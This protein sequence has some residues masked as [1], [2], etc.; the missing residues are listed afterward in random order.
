MVPSRGSEKASGR[1]RERESMAGTGGCS[2]GHSW[3]SS[4]SVD[5]MGVLLSVEN[6]EASEGARAGNGMIRYATGKD[7]FGCPRAGGIRVDLGLPVRR[8]LQLSS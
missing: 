1:W 7:H 3:V 2:S 6:E 4:P 8:L 5:W